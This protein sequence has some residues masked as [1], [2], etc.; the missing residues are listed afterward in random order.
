MT[1]L[2]KSFNTGFAQVYYYENNVK[3]KAGAVK[4]GD[5][6]YYFSMKYYAFEDG[7]YY[8]ADQS[9]DRWLW[10]VEAAGLEVPE[11]VYEWN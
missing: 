7:Q 5:D 8:I 9:L 4:L 1:Q 2:I 10:L 11:E 6:I 3:K